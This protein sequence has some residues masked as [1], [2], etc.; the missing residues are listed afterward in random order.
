MANPS[1]AMC[2]FL[3][4]DEQ[5]KE[6]SR[7]P[8]IH[9]ETLSC[10]E[11]EK[12]I[13]AMKKELDSLRKH[14]TYRLAKLPLDRRAVGCKWVFKIKR[15]ATESITR[16]KARLVAQGYTQRKGLDFQETFALVTRITSQRI[17]IATAAAKDLELFQIDVKN[18][19]LNGEIDTDI[20]MKQPIGFE[21]PHYPD[22]VW[23][24]QKGL[25]GFKQA[26]NI[27]NAAIHGYI[28]E[29]GF[30]YTSVD[31]CV[32]TISFKRGDRI[33]ITIHVDDFLVAT[34]EVHFQ[35]LVKAMEQRYSI[36]YHKADLCLGIK[37]ERDGSGGYNISQQHYLEELLKEL[38]MQDCKPSTISMS[39]EEVNALT[40]RDTG[41]KK[42]DTNSHALYCQIVGKLMYTMVGTRPDLAY[43]LSILG[44]FTTTLDTY[45]MALAKRTL[46]Y[47]KA[48]INY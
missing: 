2:A 46:A 29:L 30:K 14:N 16:Y 3:S 32:Y 42:L 18:V 21:D 37:I 10:P 22:M 31:L 24:L 1:K 13:T 34:R 36:T 47:V 44:R 4:I 7:D 40:T 15:D 8:R 9:K 26:G 12:W 19:Y 43:T 27:W 11:K 45:Y 38:N 33:I 28:L 41:D 20:Y 23:A 25:Y 35:W 48:T 6:P 17:V 39:K 5:P